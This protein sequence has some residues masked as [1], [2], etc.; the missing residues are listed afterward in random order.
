[1][2]GTNNY[3]DIEAKHRR[4]NDL[5]SHELEIKRSI[6]RPSEE[7]DYDLDRTRAE[8]NSLQQE[9]REAEKEI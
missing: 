7:R 1:M 9:I 6:Y 4:L 5:I 3:D 8:I 2:S